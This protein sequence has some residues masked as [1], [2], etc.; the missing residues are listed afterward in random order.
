MRLALWGQTRPPRELHDFQLERAF[1]RELGVRSHELHDWPEV[2]IRRYSTIIEQTYI[3]EQ[4][5]AEMA[6]QK[7]EAEA[8]R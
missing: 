5:Q 1:W 7:A 8:R 4:A 6:R 3:Y 2:K